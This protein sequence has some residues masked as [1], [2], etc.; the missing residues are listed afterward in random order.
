MDQA[1]DSNSSVW[2]Y[3][4]VD[5]L[6]RTNPIVLAA[7]AVLW[8]FIKVGLGR[9]PALETYVAIAQKPA[10]PG[11]ADPMQHYLLWSPMQGLAASV[12]GMTSPSR[13]EVFSLAL[14]AVAIALPIVLSW[15][16]EGGYLKLAVFVVIVGSSLATDLYSWVGVYDAVTVIGIGVA[17]LSPWRLVRMAGWFVVAANHTEVALAGLAVVIAMAGVSGFVDY[18]ESG[19]FAIRSVLREAVIAL[20]GIA[21][22]Y[23]FLLW[24]VGH[25]GEIESRGYYR[26]HVPGGFSAFSD[27]LLIN[28]W[29]IVFGSLGA[30]WLFF[31]LLIGSRQ[32][33]PLLVLI[34]AAVGCSVVVPLVALDQSRVIGLI[35]L[36]PA[37]WGASYACRRIPRIVLT[38]ALR[39]AMLAAII[40]PVVVSWTT[41]LV[42]GPGLLSRLM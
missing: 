8:L 36:A 9:F 25:W 29:P 23:L 35:L 4:G 13:Y 7:G 16:R 28:T 30:S 34:T 3:R 33:L 1:S 24:I 27:G 19:R 31:L 32:S 21:A 11:F 10:N 26:T 6:R 40:V 5:L 22:G 14:G 15:Q 37:Y 2:F 42:Y 39:P 38:E 12:V 18:R 41:T 20:G 17:L